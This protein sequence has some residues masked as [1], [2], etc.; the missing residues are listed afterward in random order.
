M[1]RK[2]TT[3]THHDTAS[4]HGFTANEWA[5]QTEDEAKRRQ[6][7]EDRDRQILQERVI[8]S[9]LGPSQGFQFINKA[10]FIPNIDDLEPPTPPSA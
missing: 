2:R 5:L 10:A 7:Q 9:Q 4:A 8:E 3:T 6:H 1:K